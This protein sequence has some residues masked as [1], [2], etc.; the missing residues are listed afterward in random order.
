MLT[1]CQFWNGEL[2]AGVSLYCLSFTAAWW[3][4]GSGDLHWPQNLGP[5]NSHHMDNLYLQA[6]PWQKHTKVKF[7]INRHVA[8][9][10]SS[11]GDLRWPK[12]LGPSLAHGAAPEQ[13]HTFQTPHHWIDWAKQP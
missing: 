11:S 3:Q 9:W 6:T 10:P 8:W 2:A 4:R 12:N 5:K 7:F 13:L 1:L